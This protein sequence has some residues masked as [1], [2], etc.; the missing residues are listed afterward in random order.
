MTTI[1][2]Q[3]A[4]TLLLL[5][6]LLVRDYF[7]KYSQEKGKN[8]ATK[9]D[10]EEI[11][12]KVETVKSEIGLFLQKKISYHTEKYS[13]MIEC[14]G[15]FYVWINTLLNTTITGDFNKADEFLDQAKQKIQGAFLEFLTA[16]AK[17]DIYFIESPLI[18]VEIDLR[19]KTIELAIHLDN[20]LIKG[21][22][23]SKQLALADTLVDND[24]K[25]DRMATLFA[26][27]QILVTEYY[28]QR[29]EKYSSIAVLTGNFTKMIN[30]EVIKM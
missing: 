21:H 22:T 26:E 7:K 30:A 10:I 5:V 11:T 29:N 15:K 24:Y 27:R 19:L 18:A 17:F 8:L 12:E 4:L 13:A 9:E 6:V 25:I 28:Q 3:C 16:E 2:W 20:W 14:H 23:N 1:I